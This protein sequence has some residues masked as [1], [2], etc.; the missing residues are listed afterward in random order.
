MGLG[1]RKR[2]VMTAREREEVCGRAAGL[3]RSEL[4]NITGE[5]PGPC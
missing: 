3:Y 5:T 4:V 2:K 1:R